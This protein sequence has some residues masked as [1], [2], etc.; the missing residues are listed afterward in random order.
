L[1]VRSFHR[2]ADPVIVLTHVRLI[3]GIG[4]APLDDQTVVIERGRI[5]SIGSSGGTSVPR[6]ANVLDLSD[7]TVIRGLLGVHEPMFH[8]S[9]G[10]TASSGGS[11]WYN[12]LGLGAARLDLACGITGLVSAWRARWICADLTL[13]KSDRQRPSFPGFGDQREI[14][15]L[16]EAGFTP[17]EAVHILHFERRKLDGRI[18]GISTLA[19]G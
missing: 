4:A 1:E 15:L 7:I 14:E 9:A 2:V 8:S 12:E 16:V 17:V 19:P 3:D 6:T 11:L 13:K 10:P 5:A 18:K